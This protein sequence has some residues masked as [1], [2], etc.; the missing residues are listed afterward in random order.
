MNGYYGAAVFILSN[1]FSSLPFLIAISGVT[2]TITFFMVK[3]QSEFPRYAFFCLNLFGCIAMVESVMMIVA[4]LV[5]NFLMGIIAGAGVL[6]ITNSI[7]KIIHLPILPS[8]FH[9]LLAGDYDA[10]IRVLPPAPGPPQAILAVPGILHRVRG[11]VAAGRIQ[12]RHAGAGVRP[13]V[14]GRS[15]NKRGVRADEDVRV[16]AGSFKV[17]GFKRGVFPH[18]S[19]QIPLLCDPEAEG[20]S[21]ALPAFVLCEQSS[22]SSQT[23]TATLPPTLHIS[24]LQESRLLVFA[25]GP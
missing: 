1:F 19:L 9:A 12:E 20:E 6:V 13:I 2:G 15:Q 17:V 18:H 14:S 25:G 5:P 24:S 23:T 16:V 7:N 11:V 4:S 8:Q 3:Y 10:D 22:L 21:W